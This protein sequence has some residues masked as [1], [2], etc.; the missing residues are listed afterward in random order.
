MIY[1]PTFTISLSLKAQGAPSSEEIDNLTKIYW[2]NERA[3]V[4]T[5]A[6]FMDLLPPDFDIDN[7]NMEM[8]ESH[9]Y[10]FPLRVGLN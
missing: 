2:E 7:P 8:L 10:P 6:E 1:P 3:A 5:L 4:K 9:L